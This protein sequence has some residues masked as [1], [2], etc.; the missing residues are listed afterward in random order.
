LLSVLGSSKLNNSRYTL[1]HNFSFNPLGAEVL[2]PRLDDTF[3]RIRKDRGESLD[4]KP[5]FSNPLEIGVLSLDILHVISQ[6]QGGGCRGL[7]VSDGTII[8]TKGFM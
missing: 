5:R 3:Q 7:E 6:E 4:L 2:V 8:Q 1:R